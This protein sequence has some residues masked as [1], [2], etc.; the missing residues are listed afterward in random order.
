MLGII[1]VAIL[2]VMDKYCPLTIWEASLMAKYNPGAEYT[3]GFI[4]RNIEK[5]L[6]P[7]VNPLVVTIPTYFIALFTLGVFV[8]KPPEKIK[9]IFKG[10][11]D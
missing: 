3:G 10:K 4:V 8:L 7:N 1:F 9:N 5:L 2:A 6:Y 11:K